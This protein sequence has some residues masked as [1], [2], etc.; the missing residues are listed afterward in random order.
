MNFLETLDRWDKDAFLYLNKMHTPWLDPIMDWISYSMVPVAIILLLTIFFGVKAFGKKAAL[1][2]FLALANFGV[3]D[4]VSSRLFKPFF[5]RLRPCHSP[6]FEGVFHTVGKCWGGKFGFVSSHAAN[7][8]G[9]AVFLWL[10]F[11]KRWPLFGLMVPYAIL[12]SYTRIYLAKHYP[13]DLV[14]GAALGAM[15]A[16]GFYSIWKLFLLRTG[17]VQDRR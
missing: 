12:V 15:S 13:L 16:F 8:F 7:T 2:V 9:I 11:R 5:E 17:P 6:E 3:T 1:L 14:G 4:A 10:I